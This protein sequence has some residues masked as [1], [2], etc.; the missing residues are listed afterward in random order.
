MGKGESKEM[1]GNVL[2]GNIIYFRK[3]H[4][5]AVIPVKGSK[6]AKGYDLHAI[7]DVEILAGEWA[8]VKTGL[9]WQPED[10]KVGLG[11][12]PRSGLALKFGVTVLNAP[13]T[14]D[15]DYQGDIGVILINHSK[16]DYLVSAGDR[17]AQMII[18]GADDVHIIESDTI[19]KDKT[20]RGE[21]GYG[22]TGK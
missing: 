12:R 9:C 18:E 8:L 19:C 7:E 2:T 11:I 22:S 3:L 14:I 5:K 4:D 15:A 10:D 13:G 6:K 20:E 21:G 1:T 17:V 16:V